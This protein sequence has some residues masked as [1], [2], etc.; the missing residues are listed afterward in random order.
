MRSNLVVASLFS[1]VACSSGS[2][3]D[4]TAGG[5]VGGQPSTAGT[6]GLA[7]GV[8][9]AGTPASAGSSPTGGTA[10][11][12]GAG[13]SGGANTS[14][15]SSPTAGAGAGGASAGGSGSGG[16]SAGGAGGMSGSGGSA[17]GGAGAIKSAGCD[18]ARKLMDGN[19]TLSSG[20]Q[21]RKWYV[22]APKGYDQSH[23]YRVIFMYHW[24]YGSINAIVNPPDADKNTDRPFYG[25]EDLSGDTTVFVVPEGLDNGWANTNGRDSTFTDAMLSAVTDGLCVDTS[26][27]F[28][29]GFSYGGAMSLKL[30]CT[31]PDKFRAAIVYDTGTFLSGFNQSECKTPIA[32][33][34]SHG[35]DDM[36]FNYDEGL[37][38]LGIFTQLNGCTAQTPTKAADNAHAC[39]SF[40]GCSAGHPVRFCNFGKGENNPK[41]GGPGGHY[42]SPKDP[43]QTTSW[44][45]AEAWKFI[46][47]F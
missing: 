28:T 23:P 37:K 5:G 9:Q 15:G 13:T 30:A 47:Q 11:S 19:Q 4:P 34:E 29:T 44:V 17:G 33:F 45:P 25:I 41:P 46:S 7:G 39:A 26:R 35:L 31:K 14:G 21:D 16:T 6:T 43:G 12:G 40:E 2:A 36:T 8:A 42:P 27:I 20:G 1:F 3:D 10:P 22:K 32:F 24:N 18:K 38:V